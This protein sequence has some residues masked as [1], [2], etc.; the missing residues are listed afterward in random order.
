M[1][2]DEDR[3]R[4]QKRILQ[5]LRRNDPYYYYSIPG[6]LTQ[7]HTDGGEARNR[8]I[9]NLRNRDVVRKTRVSSEVH[10][11]VV[12]RDFA[13]DIEAE[14]RR[15]NNGQ[16]NGTDIAVGANLQEHHE[17][18]QQNRNNRNNDQQQ[19]TNESGDRGSARAA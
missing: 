9:A 12:Y 14:M 11:D 10:S 1:T 16:Q 15:R 6:A 4:A 7:A 17:H 5:D 2:D 8:L 18:Q 19:V 13:N 3:I